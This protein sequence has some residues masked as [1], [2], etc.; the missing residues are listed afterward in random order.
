M[1]H[2]YMHVYIYIYVYIYMYIYIYIYIL[3][4]NNSWWQ[5]IEG[6]YYLKGIKGIKEILQV[7][8]DFMKISSRNCQFRKFARLKIPK[9]FEFLSHRSQV[10]V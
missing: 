3:K 8:L 10:S 4:G 2:P 1:F 6:V 7:V 9:K 5:N